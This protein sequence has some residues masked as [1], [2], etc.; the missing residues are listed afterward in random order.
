MGPDQRPDFA[1]PNGRPVTPIDGREPPVVSPLPAW[2]GRHTEHG[3]ESSPRIAELLAL[4][5]TDA[6]R[7]VPRPVTTG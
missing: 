3:S 2:D 6:Y 5:E 7:V 4:D 1:D